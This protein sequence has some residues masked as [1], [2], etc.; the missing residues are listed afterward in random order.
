M[1]KK[2]ACALASAVVATTALTTAHAGLLPLD[3][4]AVR[5]AE[6]LGTIDV[7]YYRGADFIAGTALGFVGAFVLTNRYYTNCGCY[8]AYP[9]YY[10]HRYAQP[11]RFYHF[12]DYRSYY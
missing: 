2:I 5:S 6:P 4:Q 7:R 3:A 10:Y 11:D 12:G 9:H 1:G 8:R